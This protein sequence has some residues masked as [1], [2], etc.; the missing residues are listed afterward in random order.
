MCLT[1]QRSRLPIQDSDFR[2]PKPRPGPV[3]S[4]PDEGVDPF[5]IPGKIPPEPEQPAP[6]LLVPSSKPERSRGLP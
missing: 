6:V 1:W 2:N 5:G 4:S 3:P